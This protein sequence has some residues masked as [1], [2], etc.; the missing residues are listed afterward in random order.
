MNQLVRNATREQAA[1]YLP[2]LITG[3]CVGALSMSEPG[4][5]SDVCSMATRAE[6]RGDRCAV[7]RCAP[8]LPILPALHHR[9]AA[10]ARPAGRR[11][12]TALALPA[13][14]TP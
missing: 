3:E 12:P 2:R 8:L 4:A 10:T 11:S 6:R 5:G 14:Q 13:P 1:R 9:A 7:F